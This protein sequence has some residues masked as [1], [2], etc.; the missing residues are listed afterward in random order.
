MSGNDLWFER[1]GDELDENEFPEED[2]FR[3]NVGCVNGV[4]QA[5]R[6]NIDLYDGAGEMLE[7]RTMDLPPWS[8]KQFNGL[9]SA[10]APVQ[11]YVD[12]YTATEGAYVYCYGS[13]LD[14]QTS[15][16]TT[17]LPQ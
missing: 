5:A 10:Y 17:V 11:G 1:P 3:A 2:D 12:V 7:A 4:N 14:N 8:N 6:V 16:P 9:F 15:D 13:V